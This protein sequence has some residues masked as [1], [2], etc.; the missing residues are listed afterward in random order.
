[1]KGGE[2]AQYVCKYCGMKNQK[3]SSLVINKC[4]KHPNGPIKGKHSPA[5]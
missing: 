5:L 2:K 4:M 1:M 3:L